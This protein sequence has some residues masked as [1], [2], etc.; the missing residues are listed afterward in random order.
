MSSQKA[1]VVQMTKTLNTVDAS[2]PRENML[3]GNA[4]RGATNFC[5]IV[6]GGVLAA[7]AVNTSGPIVDNRFK[8]SKGVNCFMWYAKM[9]SDIAPIDGWQKIYG[10]FAKGGQGCVKDILSPEGWK[11]NFP[12]FVTDEGKY[13]VRAEIK[14]LS[15]PDADGVVDSYVGCTMVQIGKSAPIPHA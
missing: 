10:S 6:P 8:T 9:D 2:H 15:E 7:K 13:M 12:A 4:A 3:C 14:F 11:H 1:V 5:S